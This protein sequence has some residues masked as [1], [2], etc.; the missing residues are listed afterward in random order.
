MNLPRTYLIPGLGADYRLY[1]GL[2]DAGMEFEVLEFMAPLKGE[3]LAEYG[4]RMAERIDTS[5]PFLL[6]GV[7]LGGMISMEVAKHVRPAR[8]ILISSVR[9]AAEFPFYFKVFRFLPIQ[10]ALP[11]RFLKVL[12]PRNPFGMDA[13]KRDIL[14]AMRR[15][16]DAEFVKW[17]INAAVH[18]RNREV[19]ENLIRLHGT[20][21]LMFPGI[22]MGERR[23]LAKGSH[24]M[25]LNRAEEVLGALEEE[26]RKAGK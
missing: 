26:L 13:G 4:K 24:V 3:T 14:E 16:M 19:P 5:E 6:G 23:K 1:K 25:V 20:R 21:D 22:L 15:D 12:A 9:S 7:S 2:E 11:A 10:R 8:V 18:W 17:A